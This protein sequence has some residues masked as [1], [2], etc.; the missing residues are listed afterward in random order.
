[1][2]HVHAKVGS[3]DVEANTQLVYL[4]PFLKQTQAFYLCHCLCLYLTISIIY[5]ALIHDFKTLGTEASA[6]VY[7]IMRYEL[8]QTER[9]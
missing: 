7:G 2:L 3:A 8:G 1:M 9:V 5:N 6:I 4:V